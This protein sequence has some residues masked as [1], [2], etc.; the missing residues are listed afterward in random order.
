MYSKLIL[1]NII[2]IVWD[3]VA[4]DQFGGHFHALTV[5][6]INSED[7]GGTGSCNR[8]EVCLSNV[9]VSESI[10]DQDARRFCSIIVLAN[11]CVRGC[12]C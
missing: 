9:S 5:M 1:Q 12:F 11:G 7:R 10:Y 8:C 4:F 6:D 3:D 2:Y